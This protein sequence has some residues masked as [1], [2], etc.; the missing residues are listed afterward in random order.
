MLG[1]AIDDG[2]F[3]RLSSEEADRLVGLL[4]ACCGDRHLAEELAQ[5]PFIRLGRSLDRVE[6]P[7]KAPAYL[8]SIARFDVL[9]RAEL[10]RARR[11]GEAVG[12]ALAA[13]ASACDPRG[14]TP[15]TA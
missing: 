1:Q 12:F 5:E 13:G 11:A 3:V 7:G 6:D 15:T 10:E 4:H 9:A 2:A 14:V 8:R